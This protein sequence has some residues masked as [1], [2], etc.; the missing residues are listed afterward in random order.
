MPDTRERIKAHTV[1]IE[2]VCVIWAGLVKKGSNY[3][4]LQ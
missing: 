2:M 4:D 3:G 1:C